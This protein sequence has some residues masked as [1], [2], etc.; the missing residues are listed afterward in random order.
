[1]LVIR[2]RQASRVCRPAGLT[3][4][5]L[6]TVVARQRL[7]NGGWRTFTEESTHI[8]SAPPS[9]S[10]NLQQAFIAAVMPKGWP[11]T[12]NTNYAA[13]VRWTAVGLVTGR[14]QS[15]LATQASLFAIGLGAGAVPMAAAIQWVLKDGVG[16]LGA[17]MY[18]TAVN[19]RFDAD[20][21][22]HRFR[23]VVAAT[24]ARSRSC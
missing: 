12:T 23:S 22:R 6:S 4:R 8:D 5:A 9:T 13:Y 16:H 7:P 14:V 20:A 21:K 15:V 3:S 11:E 1:M 2:C 10:T 18:A 17:I 19:T 24:A